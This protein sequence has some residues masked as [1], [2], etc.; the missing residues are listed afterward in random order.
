MYLYRALTKLII[1]YVFNHFIAKKVKSEK[2]QAQPAGKQVPK[3]KSDIK[4]GH[5]RPPFKSSPKKSS[6]GKGDKSK[7]NVGTGW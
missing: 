5:V 1:T 6:Q 7:Q 2:S 4:T 3:S